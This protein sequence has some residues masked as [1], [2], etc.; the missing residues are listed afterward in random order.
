MAPSVPEH[1]EAP[2]QE[3]LAT[4]QRQLGRPAR[5]VVAIAHRCPCGCPDVVRTE[6]RL[7]DGT[8]FP[9]SFY[10]TCPRLTGAISTL[11]SS[12]MM[13]EMTERLTHDPELAKQ[14]AVQFVKHPAYQ[15]HARRQLIRRDKMRR[16]SRIG[17]RHHELPLSFEHPMRSYC[18]GP[19]K[20]STA[21]RCLG[22]I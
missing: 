16:C 8:P 1:H 4:I 3:D 19:K 13:R 7:P 6:P 5:G 18:P 21:R 22:R 11:E 2:T 15:L 14:Y 9:T 17:Y 12:G 10:A 20:A